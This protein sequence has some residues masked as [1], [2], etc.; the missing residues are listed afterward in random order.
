MKLEFSNLRNTC[1]IF[2]V[3]SYVTALGTIK[4]YEKD[5][6]HLIHGKL[7]CS[8]SNGKYRLV[9]SQQTTD[10]FRISEKGWLLNESGSNVAEPGQFCLEQFYE[11]NFQILPIVCSLPLNKDLNPLINEEEPAIKIIFTVGMILSL[12]FLFSTFLVY[13]LIRDLRNLHGKS[14]MCHVATLLVAYT[15]LI[16]VQFITNNIDTEYCI[17]LGKYFK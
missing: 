16:V 6:F 3:P 11:F 1:V 15:S 10:N 14:L 17:I 13:A 8:K 4:E 9:P 5:E 2:Q 7:L 12:P